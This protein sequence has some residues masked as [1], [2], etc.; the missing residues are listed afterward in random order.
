MLTTWHPLSAKVGTN[1]VDTLKGEAQSLQRVDVN[2]QISNICP[3]IDMAAEQEVQYACVT[4][5]SRCLL[6]INFKAMKILCTTLRK[7]PS[8]A[9][10]RPQL[11]I[12]N[13]TIMSNISTLI[14]LTERLSKYPYTIYQVRICHLALF[15]H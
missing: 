14:H 1:F 6:V 8:S 4:V 11:F 2:R 9:T 3:T 12:R 5:M 10:M 13:K 7:C 15:A